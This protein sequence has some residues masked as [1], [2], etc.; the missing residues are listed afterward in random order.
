MIEKLPSNRSFGLL[1]TVI[2]ICISVYVSYKGSSVIAIYVW[3]ALAAFVGFISVVFPAWLT[4]L[5]KAWMRLGSVMHKIVSPI[6]LG[7]IFFGVI[8]PI[9]LTMKFL[10]RDE[11][12]LAKVERDTYWVG[13]IPPGPNKDSF[14]NQF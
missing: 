7:V 4:P 12:R 14:K 10:G 11:L 13:R 5:N 3:L 2:F 1:F 8:T 9:S 6:I